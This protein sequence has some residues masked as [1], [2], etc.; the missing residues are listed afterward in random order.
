MEPHW[1]GCIAGLVLRVQ[2]KSVR[3]RGF[4][5][6]KNRELHRCDTGKLATTLM[7]RDEGHQCEPMNDRLPDTIT[8]SLHQECGCFAL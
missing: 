4:R 1:G 2:R 3:S 8:L 6:R 5:R 7:Y